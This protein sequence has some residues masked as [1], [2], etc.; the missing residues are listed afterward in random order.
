MSTL[1]AFIAIELDEQTI[2]ALAGLQL[3]LKRELGAQPVKWVAP[4]SIHLTLKFLGEID[5]ALAPRVAAVLR[6]SIAGEHAF[7]LTVSGLGAFPNLQRPNVIWAGLS[8]PT[9]AAARIA[10]RLEEGCA[11][12]GIPREARPFSPHLTLGRVQ[13]EAAPD[14][15]RQIGDRVRHQR[16]G[17]I[18]LLRV[19]AVYLM[20][21]ELKPA[22][23]V[24]SVLEKVSLG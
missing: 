12:L 24:Y 10:R 1:R 20:R 19:D 3:R 9:E 16:A 4:A 14:A 11:A 13:R 5:R 8:G 7:A 21:S 15:R 23:A 17:E 2:D 22:G 6:D 18:G